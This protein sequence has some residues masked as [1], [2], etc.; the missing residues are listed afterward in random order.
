MG[1]ENGDPANPQR[2]WPGLAS[3]ELD[4]AYLRRLIS[5][6]EG[7]FDLADQRVLLLL[8]CLF[9]SDPP[10]SELEPAARALLGFRF[11]LLEPGA[12]SMSLWSES[13]QIATAVGEYLTGQLFAE[14]RFTNDGRTGI[15]H[16]RAAHARIMVWLS[17]RFR[18]GFSEWL[19]GAQLA[20][21]AAALA[22]LIDYALDEELTTRA[23][24]VLDLLLT[25]LALHSFRG[26]FAPSMGRA[27][28]NAMTTPG[29]GEAAAIWRAAFGG[30]P[31]ASVNVEQLTSLFATRERYRVPAAVTQIATEMPVRRVLISQGLDVS[32]VADELRAH[33]EFP[34]SSGLELV[35][36]WW[37]QHAFTTPETIVESMRAIRTLRLAQ[38]HRALAP[39]RRFERLPDRLLVPTL[40]A[41][42]PIT[43]GRA[44]HRANVQTIATSN[45][46]LSSTQRYRPGEFGDQQ[47]LWH[48]TLPGGIQVFGTHPGNTQL[49]VEARAPSPSQWV[50]NGINPDIAQH[51]NI[52]LAQYDLSGRRGRFEGR[53][54]ELVH[55]HFPFVQFDQ[56]RLGPT[57]VTGRR[58]DA[59]IAILGSHQFEQISETEIVQRGVHTGYAVIL[60]DDEEYTSLAG[61]LR[62]V[63]ECRLRLSGHRLMLNSPYGRFQLSWRGD[64][65][66]DT[67]VVDARYPRYDTPA[68][69]SGRNPTKLV[70]SGTRDRLCLDWADSRRAESSLDDG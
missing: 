60:G 65:M 37:G 9:A 24:M 64:F 41:L 11:S 45:Y 52:L 38:H 56:T 29:D 47:H 21:D 34:R 70:I 67:R 16:R 14:R 51:H 66:V 3:G 5:F 49:A 26:Q 1:C 50:G 61:F 59:Y 43:R 28:L 32:E 17:D 68:V 40:K 22:L 57:W 8:K 62:H 58:D 6:I 33:P 53:R 69:Q 63:K 54:S 46:L 15:R 20:N 2:V 36:F 42:N 23:A 18:F 30:R 7:R 48:A 27:Q 44:L 13:H 10:A 31:P 19:S 55:I 4:P 25:D 39:I 35:S 12:D